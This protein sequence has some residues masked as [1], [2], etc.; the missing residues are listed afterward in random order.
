[1]SE[2]TTLSPVF[3]FGERLVAAEAARNPIMAT[4]LGEPGY[5]DQLTDYSLEAA[6]SR[7][8]AVRAEL[9]DL[10]ALTPETDDERIAVAVI[11]ERLASRVRVDE[12][13]EDYRSVSVIASPVAEIRQV[14]E[15]MSAA[16]A[17]DA[18]T[19]R[20]RLEAVEGSLAT[21]RSGLLEAAEE[22][23]IAPRRH[24]LGVADQAATHAG[25]NY[26]DFARRVA[27]TCGVDVEASGLLAAAA[28]AEAA[29]GAVG[30]WL[31]SDVA[32]R[33]ETPDMAGDVRYTVMSSYYSGIDVD[34]HELYAWGVEDLRG[35]H[36]RMVA[37][38]QRLAPDAASVEAVADALDADDAGAVMGEAALV[39]RLLAFT[40]VAVEQLNGPH[41]DIDPR[42]TFC[43]AR[44]APPGSALAPYYIPPS[45]DLSRPGITWYPTNG[46]TRFPWWRIASTWY[47]ESVPGHHLQ[48]AMIILR[49]EQLTRYQRQLAWTSGVGEGWALYAERFMDELGEFAPDEEFGYLANQALRAARI[50]VDIGM[51]LGLPVP[52][53]FDDAIGESGS[54]GAT[55][56]P[57]RAVALLDRWA[58]QPHA[59]SVSEVERYLGIPGQA[60][61][62][63]LGERTWIETREAARARLGD[64]FSVKAFHQRALSM[65]PM[66]LQPFVDTLAVWDGR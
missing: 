21:W 42:V 3:D 17:D 38:G 60:I 26:R 63:K 5:D 48:G 20:A 30:E 44:I 18:Q 46:E 32:P 57:E 11:N 66:G 49:T 61:S 4:Y 14:F 19:I 29:L 35:L 55:W 16:S 56:T 65:G 22:G 64:A 39:A 6:R 24:I 27:G 45:E 13:H 31:R 52:E 1:M 41:F 12:R 40:E 37:L 28:K 59:M 50:V 10:S 9:A 51:H 34:F 62:Y 23:V 54:A 47:H 36:E 25:G 53:G 2:P 43:D 7:L 33:A 58:I 8:D 15:L